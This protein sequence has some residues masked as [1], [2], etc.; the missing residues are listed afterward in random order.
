MIPAG[1]CR[2][3]AYIF[4]FPSCICPKGKRYGNVGQLM[5]RDTGWPLLS[6]EVNRNS[7]RNVHHAAGGPAR[8]DFTKKKPTTPK[9]MSGETQNGELT[10]KL[11]STMMQPKKKIEYIAPFL[12]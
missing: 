7:L 11:S 9:V 5:G 2:H 10:P 12:R 4:N 8:I 3:G 6:W 1:K